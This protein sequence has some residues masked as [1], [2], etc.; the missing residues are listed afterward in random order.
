MASGA[1]THTHIHS[2]IESDFKK[3]GARWPAAGLR[4]VCM[5]NKDGVT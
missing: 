2:H 5:N 4:L 1:Y 3:P